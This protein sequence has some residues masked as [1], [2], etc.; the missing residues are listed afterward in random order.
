[1]EAAA[2]TELAGT[3]GGSA[4]RRPPLDES[5]RRV[6]ATPNPP[7]APR[8]TA[9]WSATIR[10]LTGTAGDAANPPFSAQTVRQR[11]KYFSPR[12]RITMGFTNIF[13]EVLL[14]IGVSTPYI[15]AS[16]NDEHSND[17]SAFPAADRS[18]DMDTF[19]YAT[20]A[21]LFDYSTAANCSPPR[22]GNPGANRS[23]TDDLRGSPMHFDSPSRICR[24][25]FFWAP[26]SKLK[27]RD[28]TAT[29]C[30][31]CTKAPTIHW[32][33]V[34]QAPADEGRNLN[35]PVARSPWPAD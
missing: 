24:R 33:G 35:R 9:C 11:Q 6:A 7:Y 19:D 22:A 5:L 1:M 13:Y 32:L 27:T 17:N 29:A 30:A 25:S 12:P 14:V 15:R 10:S 34:A 4:T 3:Q 20:E 31:A 23:A 8:V 26:I 2:G 18:R 16:L 28:S 21:E